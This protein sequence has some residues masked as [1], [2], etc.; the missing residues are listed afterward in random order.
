MPIHASVNTGWFRWL[1][2]WTVMLAHLLGLS[3]SAAASPKTLPSEPPQSAPVVVI[4]VHQTVE[5]GLQKFIERSLREAEERRAVHIILDIDTLGGRVDSAEEIGE[6]IRG[7]QVPTTAF[8]HGKAVSAGSYIALNATKIAMEPGSS[9]GAAAVVDVTGNAIDDAKVVAHWASEMRA[10][11]E[12]RGRNPKI[13]E[14]MVD[15]NVGVTM[16]EIGRTVEKGQLVSLSAEEALKVGYSEKLAA[17]QEEVIRFLGLEKH[18]VVTIEPSLAEKIARF[19]TLPWVAMILLFIGIAG[20]AIEL[21]VPGFGVPGII[22]LLGFTL[23]FFGHYIVGFAEVEH[24]VFFVL[25][26][27]LL[28]IEIFVSSFGILGILGALSLFGSVITAAYNTEQAAWNL[29][30]AFV[31][32]AVVVGV[33]MKYFQH[34]GVWNRFILRDKLTTEQGYTSAVSRTDLLGITGVTMTPLRPSG[35]ARIGEEKVD[36]VTE[37]EFIAS[38]RRVTVVHVEGMRVVV[39]EQVD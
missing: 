5:T 38:G 28:I 4:P 20:I 35:S 18:P 14:A 25:G 29:A 16:P 3:T 32:A 12:M 21:F 13:A 34:R 37:G 1:V 30:I 23:Y 17:N 31:F 10:A 7:S 11:A 2:L 19:L 22:G 39:K 15:K 26:V 8:V 24:I 36:V 27:L 9:I 33:T 6:M